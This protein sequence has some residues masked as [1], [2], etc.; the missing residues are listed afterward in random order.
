M[1]FSKSIDEIKSVVGI[2]IDYALNNSLSYNKTK[3]IRLFLDLS[4]KENHD[5]VTNHIKSTSILTE[6]EIE[7]IV[8]KL[9]NENKKL[10]ELGKAYIEKSTGKFIKVK[11]KHHVYELPKLK[12][13]EVKIVK[14]E[15][16][17]KGKRFLK[18]YLESKNVPNNK[19]DNFIKNE[20]YDK[21]VKAMMK[22]N[23][24]EVSLEDFKKG[25]RYLV[26]ENKN[27]VYEK[28]L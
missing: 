10:I 18:K 21:Y 12:E 20:D 1:R 25:Y 9:S 3:S 26:N 24:I 8:D 2:T 16:T 4:I 17:L 13:P 19:I 7:N 23:L 22:I 27:R 15:S 11:D 6:D 14:K 5:F 28:Y